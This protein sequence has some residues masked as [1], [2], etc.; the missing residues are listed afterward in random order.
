M[1]HYKDTNDH[2]HF[3]DDPKFE[4]LL[5]EGAVE[6]TDEEADNIRNAQLE[7]PVES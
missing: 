6:I 1:P 3:L 5:P 7:A 2:L 4:F